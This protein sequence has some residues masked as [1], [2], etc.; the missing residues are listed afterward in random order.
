[1]SVILCNLSAFCGIISQ[2]KSHLFVTTSKALLFTEIKFLCKNTANLNATKNLNQQNP[3]EL[4]PVKFFTLPES[5]N[6]LFWS[7]FKKQGKLMPL[8]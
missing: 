2:W 3:V 8:K 4:I 7:M 5:Q 1:V 6:Y